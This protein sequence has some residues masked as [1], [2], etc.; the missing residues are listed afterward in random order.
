MS[1]AGRPSVSGLAAPARISQTMKE[2]A[3]LSPPEVERVL[4]RKKKRVLVFAAG[5][6][7]VILERAIYYDKNDPLFDKK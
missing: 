7:P 2:E 3:L 1:R 4:G 5:E 6:R